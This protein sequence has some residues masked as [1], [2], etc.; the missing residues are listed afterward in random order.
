MATTVTYQEAIKEL[1]PTAVG[2]DTLDRQ[3]ALFKRGKAAE[4]LFTYSVAAMRLLPNAALSE[5]GRHVWDVMH[6]RHV[7]AVIFGSI[8]TP[9][10]TV[11]Q[12]KD[13]GSQQATIL[14]PENWVKMATK[15]PVMA[16]GSVIFTGSQA[17]DFFNGRVRVESTERIG[18][19]AQ[20]YEAS[21]LLG[22][23]AAG[24]ND[25]QRELLEKYP[26]GYDSKFDYPRR[27]VTSV[28]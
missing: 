13:D 20:S 27:L 2:L 24:L 22:Y 6:W 17:V 11:S 14:I 19:R 4:Q 8:K 3:S 26:H 21:M 10:F 28:S 16:F 5:L 25:Y 15:E 12:K 23:P 9:T 7:H 18:E 1:F